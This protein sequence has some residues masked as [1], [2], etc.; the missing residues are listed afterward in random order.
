MNR[1]LFHRYHPSAARVYLSTLT[2]VKAR[3]PL[4]YD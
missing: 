4:F 1:L 3:F 2:V